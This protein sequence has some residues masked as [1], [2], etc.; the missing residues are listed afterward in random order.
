MFTDDNIDI[1]C[2]VNRLFKEERLDAESDSTTSLSSLSKEDNLD[3]L[4]NRVQ[5]QSGPHF[6]DR[7]CHYN[8]S[9]RGKQ[10][11]CS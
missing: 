4:D 7:F 10:N 11:F 9:L 8:T 5:K 2:L 6:N 1:N 3:Y